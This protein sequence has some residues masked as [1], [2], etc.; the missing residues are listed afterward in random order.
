[1]QISI[2]KMSINEKFLILEEIWSSM[3]K[4]AKNSNFTPKWHIEV[5]EDREKLAQNKDA[6]SSLSS[7]QERLEKLL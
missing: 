3:S 2:E 5:L 4:D 7:A 6:F 1:M